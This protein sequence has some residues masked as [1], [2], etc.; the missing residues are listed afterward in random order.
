MKK[1]DNSPSIFPSAA[2]DLE[3]ARQSRMESASYRLAYAD[4]EFLLR[5]DLR[6]VRLQLEWLKPDIVQEDVFELMFNLDATDD[7]LEFATI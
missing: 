1:S 7:Q 6:A 4:S 3:R 2:E 5:D